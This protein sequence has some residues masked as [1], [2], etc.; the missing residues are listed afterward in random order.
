MIEKKKNLEN[1]KINEQGYLMNYEEWD[2]NIAK[3]LAELD[4]INLNKNHWDIIYA[5]RLFYLQYHISPSMR[6]LVKIIE[7][8]YGKE[9]GNTCYLYYLFP[10]GPAKQVTKISGLP[11][12][13]RC[14]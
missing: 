14:M 6:M 5:V 1:I 11:Q 13:I 4:G 10:K 7:K 12:P 3:Y 9:K 8:T 2:E